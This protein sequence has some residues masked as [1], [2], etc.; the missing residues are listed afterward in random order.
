M[1]SGIR[2]M[3]LGGWFEF[4][5]MYLISLLCSI[6]TYEHCIHKPQINRTQK[7]QLPGA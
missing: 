5:C 4:L 2:W 1:D 7:L 3:T 6:D